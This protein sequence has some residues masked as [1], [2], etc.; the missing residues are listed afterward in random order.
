[1]RSILADNRFYSLLERSQTVV[2]C[3]GASV[4]LL[5]AAC[6]LAAVINEALGQPNLVHCRPTSVIIVRAMTSLGGLAMTTRK[7]GIPAV[8]PWLLGLIARLSTA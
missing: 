7:R 3:S 4:I 1:M 8:A 5:K 6:S 2:G